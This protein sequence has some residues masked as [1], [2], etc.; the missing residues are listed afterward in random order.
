LNAWITVPD[1]RATYQQAAA[2]NGLTWFKK[3]SDLDRNGE[4]MDKAIGQI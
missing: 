1:V 3:N 4:R 2:N